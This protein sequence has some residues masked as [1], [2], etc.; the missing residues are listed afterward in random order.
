[1]L[2]LVAHD[3]CWIKG[4]ADDPGD[5]CAHGRVAFSIDGVSIIEPEDGEWSVSTAALY[6]LRTLTADHTTEQPVAEG[7]FL[8]PCCGFNAWL[9]G[10]RY[11][12]MCMGC[13]E[14][15]D[16]W[17]RHE[18][19]VVHVSVGDL[20]HSILRAE[21]QAAVLGF[22]RQIEEFYALSSPKTKPAEQLDREGWEAFWTE[23]KERVVSG[24]QDGT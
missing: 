5:Q 23:W 1:M 20:H 6:L 11:S 16:T 15:I 19:S 22:V 14:G 12:V 10:E 17:V 4:A 13:S 7:N 3:L 24:S 21:W 2:S 8:F 9:C 18:G